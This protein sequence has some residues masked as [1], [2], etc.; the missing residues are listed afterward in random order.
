MAKTFQQFFSQN[1]SRT[2]QCSKFQNLFRFSI[3]QKHETPL[4]TIILNFILLYVKMI[5]HCCE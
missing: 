1:I 4:N 5:H 2:L 3:H